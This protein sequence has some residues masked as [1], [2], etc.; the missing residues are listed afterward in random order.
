ML[1][2]KMP[3]T[4]HLEELRWRLIKALLA[5]AVGFA[6]SYGFADALFELLT[7][8][9]LALNAAAGGDAQSVRLIGTGIGE[10][11]FTKLKVSLIAGVF[12][13]SPIIL[14]QLWRFVAPGLFP[15]ERRYARPFVLFGTL[16]FVVGAWFCYAMVLPVGYRFF[17]EQYATIGINPEIRISEYLSFTARMLLAFGVTFELPVFTFFFA[18]IGLVTH[19][20]MLGYARY[21]VLLIFIV[22]AVLTPG[23]DVASQLLM[24]GP[25]LLLYVISIGVA[26]AFGRRQAAESDSATGSAA[27]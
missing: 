1:D 22:A 23:P 7:R 24:A 17:I 26:Y 5:I 4:A 13:A 3:L 6:A 8:P 15:Q 16:F 19:Q 11:F 18:R 21:A 27:P 9:L 20:M 25:L 2:V 12:L 14:Y 10:A